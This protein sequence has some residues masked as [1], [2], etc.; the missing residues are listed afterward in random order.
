MG[1]EADF[2]NWLWELLPK[3]RK[4][5]VA[6][7]KRKS[8]H[9]APKPTRNHKT[10]GTQQHRYAELVTTMKRDHGVRI[11]RWRNSTTGCAWE[12][13]YEDGHIVR[14]VQAPYPKGPVSCAVFLHEVGHHAI[15]FN[16]YKPRCYEEYKAWEWALDAMRQHGVT[17]T[18]SVER[19]VERALQYAVD[20]AQRRGIKRLPVELVRY[21]R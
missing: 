10:H 6:P 8:R 14:M 2:V 12:V 9:A 20:K 16:R 4:P 7:S 15:G 5:K 17:I 13:R 1:K 21:A 19:R 3:S 11:H 18:P